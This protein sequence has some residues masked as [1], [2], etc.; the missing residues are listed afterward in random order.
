MLILENKRTNTLYQYKQHRPWQFTAEAV[1]TTF[2][3]KA[4][5]CLTPSLPHFFFFVLSF[6]ARDK[7]T[8]DQQYCSGSPPFCRSPKVSYVQ[9]LPLLN[10]TN[11]IAHLHRE[12]LLLLKRVQGT[13][14]FTGKPPS[15]TFT[16]LFLGMLFH[17]LA[18]KQVPLKTASNRSTM[19]PTSQRPTAHSN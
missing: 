8:T 12:V 4:H 2:K 19:H 5:T 16:K 18:S 13:F 3:K 11:T 10:G 17:W 6:G 1:K 15:D 14:T 9:S 7:T